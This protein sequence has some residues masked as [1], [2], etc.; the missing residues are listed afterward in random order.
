MMADQVGINQ[1]SR[2]RPRN[3]WASGSACGNMYSSWI[4]KNSDVSVLLSFCKLG[5]DPETPANGLPIF[6]LPWG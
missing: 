3:Q 5:Y 2:P 6:S 1:Y 4:R